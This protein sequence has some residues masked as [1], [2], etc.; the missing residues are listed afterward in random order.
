[1]K[2]LRFF[3]IP[4]L[5]LLVKLLAAQDIM[6]IIEKD[7]DGKYLDNENII[8]DNYINN[9][10]ADINSVIEIQLNGD[11]LYSRI[12]SIYTER[13]PDQL[14][15]KIRLLV[16]AMEKRNQTLTRL[17]D[18][19][20]S[21]DYE[22]FKSDTAAYNKYINDLSS[23]TQVIY[24]IEKI[25]DRIAEEAEK[26]EDPDEMYSGVYHAAA[27]VLADMENEIEQFSKDQ[28]VNIQFGGW[29]ITKNQ[30]IPV[31]FQGFDDI[32]PQDPYEVERWQFIPTE[33]QKND[34][35][36]LQRLAK[37]NKDLGLNILKVTA[38]NQLE[39]IKAFGNLKLQQLAQKLITDIK[40]IEEDFSGNIEPGLQQVFDSMISLETDI[41]EFLKNIDTRLGYYRNLSFVKDYMLVEFLEH[42][43][44]DIRFITEGDGLML[45]T[46]IELIGN[47]LSGLSQ[48]I[49]NSATN[50]KEQ[51]IIL[52][53]EYVDGYKSFKTFVIKG[54]REIIS[55]RELDMAALE[56]GGNVYKHSLSSIPGSAEIDLVNTGV[57]TDGDRLAIKMVVSDKRAEQPIL[58]ESRELYMFRVLPHIVTTVGVIFADPLANTAIQTQFQM[59]PSFNILFKGIGDQGRRRKSVIYNRLFDWGIG[60]HIAA[61]DFNKDDVPEMAAGIVISSL[62]DYLQSGFAFNVFTG[63]PYWFFGLR[64]PVPSFNISTSTPGRME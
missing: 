50:V 24:E 40:L 18:I 13:L 15:E 14:S 7:K 51:F 56:F 22:K 61:P 54:A 30:N 46:K 48:E 41:S 5:F 1:M 2:M 34:F 29:L 31:H 52:E 20:Q 47:Q 32:A 28:G 44:D 6:T 63:D 25:D 45:K 27:K 3:F 53:D 60:I 33:E 58:L 37:E 64:F 21:Y 57:R 38:Q 12:G 17:N 26:Y 9:K 59:A 62:H 11:L 16:L 4:V 42:A 23:E 8:K 19:V 36:E 49:L 39:A 55:G 43:R 35:I 10:I